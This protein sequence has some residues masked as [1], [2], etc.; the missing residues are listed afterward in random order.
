MKTII[1]ILMFMPTLIGCSGLSLAERQD[2]ATTELSEKWSRSQKESIK[3]AIGA[4]A[5]T[6]K[7]AV[8]EWSANNIESGN[9]DQ[10]LMTKLENTIPGGIKMLYLAC[11]VGAL[12]MIAGWVKRSSVAARA[13]FEVAD[14]SISNAIN[15][16]EAKISQATTAEE[17]SVHLSTLS[18]LEK[19]RG[20]ASRRV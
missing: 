10:A 11:G 3:V 6:Q 7:P 20:I 17:K 4:A 15:K 1:L 13:V 16:V 18:E 19:A 12:I 2:N 9:G 8:V 5:Q 14:R